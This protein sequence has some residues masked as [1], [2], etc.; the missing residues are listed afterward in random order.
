MSEG[1]YGVAEETRIM[2]NILGDA[3]NHISTLGNHE[4]VPPPPVISLSYFNKTLSK[5]REF[6]ENHSGLLLSLT[7]FWLLVNIVVAIIALVK[8]SL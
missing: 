4:V 3:D 8:G 2:M 5:V 6:K 1:I 7:V